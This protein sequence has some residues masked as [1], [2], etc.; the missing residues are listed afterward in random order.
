MELLSN[1]GTLMARY[2]NKWVGV[3]HGEV[4]A[5]VDDLDSLLN[6]LD[7]EDVPRSETA[8]GVAETEHR[9]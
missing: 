9:R 3:C 5:A 6:V 7:Q 2:P 8:I 1:D 4:Q